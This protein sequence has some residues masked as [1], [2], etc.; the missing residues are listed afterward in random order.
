[1]TQAYGA[2]NV[3]G[4]L[5]RHVKRRLHDRI[6]SGRPADIHDDR[7]PTR[8]A[9]DFSADMQQLVDRGV[10]VTLMF[11]GS[12]LE[13]FGHPR[14]LHDVFRGRPW[15]PRV[16]CVLEAD[17]DHTMTLAESQAVLR[18]RVHEWLSVLSA[19]SGRIG[20]EA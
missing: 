17:V 18:N 1:M 11:T 20:R 15:L 4:R 7:T 3:C 10:A 14:Q 19:G 2:A 12:V 9:A 16:R 13:T 8:S 5:A 6:A